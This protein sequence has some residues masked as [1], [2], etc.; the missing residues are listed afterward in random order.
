MIQ[1]TPSERQLN[2]LFRSLQI[3][4]KPKAIEQLQDCIWKIWS[5]SNCSKVNF[6]LNKGTEYL[7]EGNTRKAI[8][9][10]TNIIGLEPSFA[11][12]YVRRADAYL[13]NGELN[14]AFKDFK[15]ALQIEPRRFDAMYGIAHIYL[16]IYHIK[17]AFKMLDRVLQL[18]PHEEELNSRL[19]LLRKK[20]N[21]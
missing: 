16:T 9:I 12:A 15:K 21:A 1:L 19:D 18:M 11:E 3:A 2:Q 13:Q 4:T 7:E 20:V 14:A 8:S 10:F 5:T 6:A 17:G